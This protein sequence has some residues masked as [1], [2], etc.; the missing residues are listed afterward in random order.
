MV[1]TLAQLA[2]PVLASPTDA[3]QT[4]GLAVGDVAIAPTSPQTNSQSASETIPDPFDPANLRISQDFETQLGVK[5]ALITVP[6][7]KPAKE[8]FCRVHPSLEYQLDT[9]AINLK[10]DQEFYLADPKL[11][12][13]LVGEPTYGPWSF[14][15]SVNRQGVLFLW[16]LRLPGTDGKL[17]PWSASAI[18]AVKLARKKWCRV[19]ANM[20]LGAYEVTTSIID[21]PAP[22]FPDIPFRDLLKIAFKDRFIDSPDH[23]VL[24]KLRGEA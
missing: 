9:F 17:D 13:T 6:V 24:R 12:T 7:R 21:D 19:T 23:L 8:W 10:E 1:S 3:A 15:T 4:A 14:V 16:P 2:A 18:E 22:Q 11:R 5:K 20:S